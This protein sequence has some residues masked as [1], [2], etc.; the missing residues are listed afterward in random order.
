MQFHDGK[1]TVISNGHESN[2]QFLTWKPDG[3][4]VAGLDEYPA[5]K[6]AS[7]FDL[8]GPVPTPHL[9]LMGYSEHHWKPIPLGLPKKA[10][11]VRSVAWSPT[12]DEVVVAFGSSQIIV[13]SAGVWKTLVKM[14]LLPGNRFYAIT[15]EGVCWIRTTGGL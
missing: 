13:K 3:T 15:Q 14:G 2:A 5:P 6:Q 11:G 8:A 10:V 4:L 1:S 7:H 12:G 9:K